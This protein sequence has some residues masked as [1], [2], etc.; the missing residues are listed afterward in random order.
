[1]A[2]HGDEN[3]E[4]KLR[5]LYDAL[6]ARS[7]KVRAM[8][9]TPPVMGPVA[10]AQILPPPARPPP[11]AG[12]LNACRH[13]LH[14]PP[15]PPC[16]LQQ[17]VKLADAALKKYKGDQLV[18]ALK[19]YA[20]H[21]SGKHEEALQVRGRLLPV[22]LQSLQLG[23]APAARPQGAPGCYPHA[24][25]PPNQQPTTKHVAL[26]A[27]VLPTADARHCGGG[28]GGGASGHD[29]G[30]HI[31]GRGAARGHHRRLCRRG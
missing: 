22:G 19:G 20:L 25:V 11:G 30:L 23:A 1:M 31:Q 15:A 18:R 5:P 7:Y 24:N 29:N 6:D 16:H 4:R 8:G 14:P 10:A 2:L 9:T 26:A 28:A 21:R 27:A 17:A 3:Y 13:P 12:Q